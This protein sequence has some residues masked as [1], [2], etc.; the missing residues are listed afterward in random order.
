MVAVQ[1]LVSE[2]LHFILFCERGKTEIMKE[3]FRKFDTFML[4]HGGYALLIATIATVGFFAVLQWANDYT[5]ENTKEL[6]IEID[7]EGLLYVD[8]QYDDKEKVAI[9]W[10][11]DGGSIKKLN[12]EEQGQYYCYTDY[13]EKIEWNQKDLDGYEYSTA[14]IRAVLYVKDEENEYDISNYIIEKTI[15][16]TVE[17]SKVVKTQNRYFSNPIRK[18]EDEHWSQIYCVEENVYRYRTGEKT[19]EDY[20]LCWQTTSNVISEVDYGAGY[21]NEIKTNPEKEKQEILKGSVLVTVDEECENITLNAYL[22]EKE[23][24]DKEKIEENK[25]LFLTKI[26]IK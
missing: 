12:N 1:R 10:E 4:K 26:E 18:D 20:V 9:L 17:D 3:M 22:I 7:D 11:T 6:E 5:K 8:Y 15:T 19:K 13:N 16:V 14:T 24:Y 21:K 23:I 2:Q 25:K